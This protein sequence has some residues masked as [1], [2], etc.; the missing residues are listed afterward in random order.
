MPNAS[1]KV[2]FRLSFSGTAQPHRP[3][4]LSL[5]DLDNEI[6][7]CPGWPVLSMLVV[8]EENVSEIRCFSQFH[9]DVT[10]GREQLKFTRVVVEL[11]FL[12]NAIIPI[13]KRQ[14]SAT[15]IPG[16]GKEWYEMKCQNIK[17]WSGISF[18]LLLSN[19]K[20]KKSIG[21]YYLFK[22]HKAHKTMLKGA[23]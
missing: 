12:N 9:S 21:V 7:C 5:Y 14:M 17:K 10:K 18:S 3:N 2:A 23:F 8:A 11:L 22:G 4:S 19:S 20:I 16:K 15:C 6:L 13:Q 1:S